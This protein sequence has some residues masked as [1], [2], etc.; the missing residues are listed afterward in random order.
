MELDP[1]LKRFR[2]C[3]TYKFLLKNEAQTMLES[4][5]TEANFKKY[6]LDLRLNT[7]QIMIGSSFLISNEDKT[8]KTELV[9]EYPEPHLQADF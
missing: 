4:M 3:A 9:M 1:E 6:L 5:A 7:K 2:G 8:Q